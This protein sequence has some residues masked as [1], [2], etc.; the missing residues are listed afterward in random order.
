MEMVGAVAGILDVTVRTT[1]KV[2]KLCQA[3]QDA[4]EDVHNLRDDLARTQHFLS[5]TKEGMQN[6]I[7]GYEEVMELKGRSPRQESLRLLID[8]GTHV[9]ERIEAVINVLYKGAED[10]ETWSKT[11]RVVWLR[12]KSKV[13]KLRK[14]LNTISLGICRLLI[15]QSVN[16]SAEIHA[17]IERSGEEV[18]AH[19]EDHLVGAT[20]KVTAHI[21]RALGSSEDVILSHLHHRF[22]TLELDIANSVRDSI[23]EELST[24]KASPILGSRYESI[25]YK[26][27]PS[28]L[29]EQTSR[30]VP[31]EQD[32]QC[33]PGCPCECH[34]G[35]NRRHSRWGVAALTP[36]MGSISITWSGGPTHACTDASCRE[37][38]SRRP[39]R[40]VSVVYRFPDWLARAALSV[41]Y[42]SNFNGTPELVIRVLNPL[43]GSRM[44]IADSIFGY[45]ARNDVEGVKRLLAERRGSVYDVWGRELQSPL[46]MAVMRRHLAVVKV[47]MQAGADPY[48]EMWV[49]GISTKGVS[50]TSLALKQYLSHRV[51]QLAEL[52]PIAHQFDLEDRPVPH[53]AVTGFLHLDLATALQN[54]THR[55]D[56]NRRAMGG[57]APIHLAAMRGDY[58]SIKLLLRYGADINI[59]STH[60]GTTALH[61]ACSQ[62]RPAVARLLIS[63]GADV[64]GRDYLGQTPLLSTAIHV[65]SPGPAYEIASLLIAAGADPEV[66]PST[67][68]CGG[69]P[70]IFAAAFG[71]S[72]C[73]RALVERGANLDFRDLDGDNAL[74]GAV[75]HR[76]H[77]SAEILLKGGIS[78]GNVNRQGR[79]IMHALARCADERMLEVFERCGAVRKALSTMDRDGEGRT[80]AVVFDERKGVSDSAGLRRAWEGFLERVE[81]ERWGVY[82]G[83]AEGEGGDG[84]ETGEGEE[85][86]EEEE[87]EFVDAKE[88]L[89]E[90]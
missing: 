31:N 45:V 74:F 86:D 19:I 1:S 71:S 34:C 84:P 60:T 53:M 40:E 80:A 85:W 21:D 26:N 46:A 51:D 79:T 17:S 90:T 3:W 66:P 38:Q 76:N 42:S 49:D 4:P 2:W 30:V 27:A 47:L 24:S 50:V 7:P 58:D 20:G 16:I 35:G 48:Q 89:G 10:N 5:E 55:A 43:D 11:M 23:H 22:D 83:E 9:I 52:L 68:S 61:Q 12:Y 64:N 37:T 6:A 82:N 62:S 14:E 33:S 73:V 28:H 18:V 41:L 25:R 70:V 59:H 32:V 67:S 72:G 69:T 54:P 8:K 15:A 57:N 65:H 75:Y 36:I 88:T 39:G 81:G 87:R 78:L 44:L 13:A 29:L 63:A 77:D 56:I